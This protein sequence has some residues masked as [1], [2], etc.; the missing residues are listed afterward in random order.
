MDLARANQLFSENIWIAKRIAYAWRVPM[1]IRRDLI[2]AAAMEG[3]WRAALKHDGIGDFVTYAQVRVRGAIRDELRTNDHLPRRVRQQALAAN[4]LAWEHDELFE[5]QHA[6]TQLPQD[7][8]L[9]TRQAIG[10][11]LPGISDLSE[12]QRFVVIEHYFKGRMFTEIADELGVSEPRI[13][14]LYTAALKHLRGRVP[15]DLLPGN[16][17]KPGIPSEP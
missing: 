13:S 8:F 10:A 16:L 3:L 4:S 9:I 1:H 11:V 15:P 5:H 7:E 14:Q 12:R 6:A 17:V 2:L